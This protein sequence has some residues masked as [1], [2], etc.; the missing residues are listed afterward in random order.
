MSSVRTKPRINLRFKDLEEMDI[1]ELRA[2]QE[3]LNLQSWIRQLIRLEIAHPRL[4]HGTLEV[5]LKSQLKTLAILE[6]LVEKPVINK[7][8]VISSRKVE[9]YNNHNE[10]W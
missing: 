2:N 10:I 8:E 9:H 5:A 6:T 1:I 4:P 7:A 3:G